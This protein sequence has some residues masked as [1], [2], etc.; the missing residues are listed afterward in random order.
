MAEFFLPEIFTQLCNQWQLEF[1]KQQLDLNVA[2]SKPKDATPSQYNV[3]LP[4]LVGRL[5]PG[6]HF[7]INFKRKV[8]CRDE[9]HLS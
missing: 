1:E 8:T 6:W 4:K 2:Y 7:G 5:K 3:K 9:T